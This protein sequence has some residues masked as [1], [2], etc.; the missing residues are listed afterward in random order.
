MGTS[1]TLAGQVPRSPI[2]LVGV[3]FDGS[4]RRVGQ[5]AAPEAL[6]E[7]GL[8]VAL[9][10]RADVTPDVIVSAPTPTRGPSGLFRRSADPYTDS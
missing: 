6:R 2:E 7:A 4:G 5:A 3:R 9:R 8:A 10:E 1:A